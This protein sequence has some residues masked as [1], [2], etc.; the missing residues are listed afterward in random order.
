VTQVHSFVDAYQ[1]SDIQISGKLSYRNFGM[2]T[3]LVQKNRN[4]DVAQILKQ[5][6]V[7]QLFA[8]TG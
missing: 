5:D 8:G 6:D 7:A 2:F 1:S 3:K 4:Q